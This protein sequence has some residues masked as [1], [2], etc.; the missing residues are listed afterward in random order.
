MKDD[1]EQWYKSVEEYK[2]SNGLK[3]YFNQ[4]MEQQ[5][6][7][8]G[9]DMN[10]RNRIRTEQGIQISVL[11]E[12]AVPHIIKNVA[13]YL[14]HKEFQNASNEENDSFASNIVNFGDHNA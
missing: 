13:E 5:Y 10:K 8:Y 2:N 3:K 4:N 14:N 6:G 11:Q 9:L 1:F 12:K 7:M